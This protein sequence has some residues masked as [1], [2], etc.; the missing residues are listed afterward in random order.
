MALCLNCHMEDGSG[1]NQLIPALKGSDYLVGKADGLPCVIRHGIRADSLGLTLR[2]M[3]AHPK[4]TE[5][6]MTNLINYLSLSFGNQKH[7]QLKEIKN[8]LRNCP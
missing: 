6:E 3:P 4:M 1:L 2:Y 5:V 7:W 8:Q